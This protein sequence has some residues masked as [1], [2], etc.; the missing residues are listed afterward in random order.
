MPCHRPPRGD[1]RRTFSEKRQRNDIE[2]QPKY[3]IMERPFRRVTYSSYAGSIAVSVCFSD[4]EICLTMKR[5][6]PAICT[7]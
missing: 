1:T 7:R 2:W 4:R 5:E 6:P 3:W